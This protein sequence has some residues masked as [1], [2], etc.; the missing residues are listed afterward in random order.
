[1]RAWTFVILRNAYLTDMFAEPAIGEMHSSYDGRTMENIALAE[2]GAHLSIW[3]LFMFWPHFR[4][5][6]PGIVAFGKC[7]AR[8]GCGRQP[9]PIFNRVS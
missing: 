2:P 7:V 9:K 4:L 5:R 6:S 8:D 3:A 1:M